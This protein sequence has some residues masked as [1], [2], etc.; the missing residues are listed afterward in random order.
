MLR[1][2]LI[3]FVFSLAAGFFGF[4]GVAVATS[5]IAQ[6]LFYIFLVLFV[7]TLLGRVATR[8]DKFVTK[9]L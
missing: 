3:F 6:I 1:W 2:T 7:I 8:G 4:S 5:S 9:S